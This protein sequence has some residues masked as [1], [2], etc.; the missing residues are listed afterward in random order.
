MQDKVWFTY[1]ARIQAHHRLQWMDT[2]S[3]F[4]LVW[5]AILGAVLA[6][7]VIRYPHLL[8]CDT[9]ILGAILS[10]ALLG[11]SLS[12]TNRDF[13]G[14]AMNMR[15]NYLA[16][17]NLY[18]E[19]SHQQPIAP[20][21]IRKYDTLLNEVEN[22][23]EMDDKKFRV[24]HAAQLTSRFPAWHEYVQVYMCSIIKYASLASLYLAPLIIAWYM[25]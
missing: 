9:D 12:I 1:K 21:Y 13:R 6:I 22:H 14:R 24:A 23:S 7:V 11:V 5:Y 3:Q 17:Q 16:L 2:H 10:I 18:N 15:K 20:E 8:G 4:L 19:I 25:S